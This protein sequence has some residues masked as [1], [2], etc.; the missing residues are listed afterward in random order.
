MTQ[1]SREIAYQIAG[2]KNL[3]MVNCYKLFDGSDALRGVMAYYEDKVINL[4]SA[5]DHY[6]ELME[7]VA[8]QYAAEAPA[9][10][11][12]A[13]DETRRI[14]DLVTE[15]VS[16]ELDMRL[17]AY[18]ETDSPL[19]LPKAFAHIYILPIMRFIIEKLYAGRQEAIS[20]Y[21]L[22]RDWFGQGLIT[23]VS[24]NERLHFPYRMIITSDH[25]YEVSIRNVMKMGD[26]F[27][28]GIVFGKE[29]IKVSFTEDTYDYRGELIIN[30]EGSGVSVEFFAKEAAAPLISD[31]LVCEEKPEMSPTVRAAKLAAGKELLWKAYGLPWGNVIFTADDGRDEYRIL[32]AQKSGRQ[33]SRAVAYRKATGDEEPKLLFGRHSFM[34]YEQ[35]EYAE[36][37][38]LEMPYPGQADYS[39]R[40][41]GR[42]YGA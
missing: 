40:Y 4:C 31:K 2:I 42:V 13:D 15:P 37:H 5:D 24:H 35:E 10:N 6:P 14:L 26:V 23:A 25:S 34:L 39:V 33:L 8:A 1:Q 18:R 41:A 22:Y 11:I 29:R 7:R 16:R 36:A 17:A 27:K 20:F 32:Y 19:F 28:A 21:E 12:V 38:M 30:L 9:G 3:K